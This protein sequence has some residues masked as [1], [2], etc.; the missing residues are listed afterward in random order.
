MKYETLENPIL[1]GINALNV[2]LKDP[3]N[4]EFLDEHDPK[5]VEQAEKAVKLLETTGVDMLN[6]LCRM[7]TAL[8][9]LHIGRDH[10][11]TPQAAKACREAW[12]EI[13]EVFEKFAPPH[14]QWHGKS[15]DIRANGLRN[16]NV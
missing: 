16:C 3:R 6:V 10:G 8:S 4:R 14:A 5:A 2:F 11:I 7:D 13:A 1:Q 12:A 15:Q 9:T